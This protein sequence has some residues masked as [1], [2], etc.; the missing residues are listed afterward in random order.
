MFNISKNTE[1]KGIEKT[2][3]KIG[4]IA[5]CLGI[6][7]KIRN[8]KYSYYGRIV[9][10]GTLEI[11]TCKGIFAVRFDEKNGWARTLEFVWKAG[12]KMNDKR[13]IARWQKENTKIIP[14]RLNFDGDKDIIHKLDEKEN[15]ARY[16]KDLI[17]KD[18]KNDGV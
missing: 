18:I 3:C 6:P 16:I 2:G 8:V 1:I 4:H 15:K 5:H 14:I 11:E 7:S 9:S 17:R 13:Y 10:K 12:K